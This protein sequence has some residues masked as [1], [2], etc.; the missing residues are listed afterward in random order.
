MTNVIEDSDSDFGLEP[1]RPKP[2]RN[3]TRRTEYLGGLHKLLTRGIPDL[4]DAAGVLDTRVLAKEVGVSYQAVYKWFERNQVPSKRIKTL[5]RLSKSTKKKPR[6]DWTPITR[7]D[8]WEF[9][10]R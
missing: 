8:F 5:I 4:V 9:L 2:K 3:K 6:T 10:S 7:D 1:R